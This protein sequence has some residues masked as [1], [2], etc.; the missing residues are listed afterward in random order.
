MQVLKIQPKA[1]LPHR[2]LVIDCLED[3]DESIRLKALDLLS[4][5][6]YMHACLLA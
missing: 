4:G 6:Q 3:R 2:D 1:V 5:V